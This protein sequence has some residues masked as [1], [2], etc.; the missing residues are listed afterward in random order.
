MANSEVL[1]LADMVSYQPGSVVSRKVLGRKGGNVTLF[2]FAEGEGLTEHTSPYDALVL[3]LDGQAEIRIGGVK[4]TVGSGESIVLP[5]RVP[6]AL[7]AR[8]PF[9]MLLAMIRDDGDR[10]AEP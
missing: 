4:Y 9:K 8:V 5:A 2:A 3:V 10:P 6:H 7:D 1:V